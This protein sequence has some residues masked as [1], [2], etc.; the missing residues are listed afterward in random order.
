MQDRPVIRTALPRRRWQLADHTATLLG[1]ID[2]GD[3]RAY[4]YLL[5]LVPTGQAEPVLYV[6]CEPAPAASADAGRYLL[7]VISEALTDVLDQADDW[8]DADRFAEQA[9]DI[10]RQVL[11]LRAAEAVRLM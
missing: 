9:L 3:T 5:A 2:S 4:R 11:G 1:D 7:R 10:A 8:G 6:T